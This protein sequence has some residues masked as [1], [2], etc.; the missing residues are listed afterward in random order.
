MENENM[1]YWE[2]YAK[3]MGIKSAKAYKK[4]FLSHIH[5]PLEFFEKNPSLLDMDLPYVSMKDAIEAIKLAE[6]DETNN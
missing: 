2:K 5:L 4:L 1:K 3:M 6:R